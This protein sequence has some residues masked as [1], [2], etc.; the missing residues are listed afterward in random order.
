MPSSSPLDSILSVTLSFPRSPE[1]RIVEIKYSPRQ[2]HKTNAFIVL[3]FRLH[4][5]PSYLQAVLPTD[6]PS[7]NLEPNCWNI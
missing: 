2:K 5:E 4:T 7:S 1:L 6:R 3:S